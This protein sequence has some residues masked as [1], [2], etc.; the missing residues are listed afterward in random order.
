[1]RGLSVRDAR[2]VLSLL[3]HFASPR[4]EKYQLIGCCAWWAWTAGFRPRPGVS[5]F[6][7]PRGG[8][9]LPRR[10][11]RRSIFAYCLSSLRVRFAAYSPP[12]HCPKQFI[13]TNEVTSF[14]YKVSLQNVRKCHDMPCFL[15][16]CPGFEPLW[17]VHSCSVFVF[18]DLR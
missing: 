2:L 13:E 18:N 1:M 15:G 7:E 4:G 14:W 3:T 5:T 9:A 10:L 12:I 8:S 16:V 17:F 11:V 6:I